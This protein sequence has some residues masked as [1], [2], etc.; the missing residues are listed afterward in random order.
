MRSDAK[1]ISSPINDLSQD[2]SKWFAIYTKYKC[3]KYVVEQLSK[4]GIGAYVPIIQKVKKYASRVKKYDLPLLN[5]YVFVKI[6]K[7]EYVRVLE[8]QYVLNFVKQRR[9]LISIPEEEIL[10]LKK[11]VGELEG[12]TAGNIEFGRGDLVE[13]VGGNLTGIRGILEEKS[14]KSR[15]TIKLTSVGIQLSIN[16]AKNDLQLV[17]KAHFIQE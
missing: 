7:E 11:V 8:T 14:G 10:I 1:A 5:N 16:V 9:N 6:T 17:R 15:F 12:V 2:E 3:E 13:I 4:K